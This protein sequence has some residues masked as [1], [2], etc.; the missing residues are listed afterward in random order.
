MGPMRDIA[1]LLAGAVRRNGMVFGAS[2]HRAE[3]W[4]FFEGGMQ[5]PSDVKEPL[6]SGLYG[7]AFPR[8]T[9]FG[10]ESQPT[11]TFLNDWLA[12]TVELVERYR[13]QVLWF[14]WWIEQPAFEP[15]RQKFAAYYYNQ[16]SRWNRGVVINYKL[17][18]FPEKAA[19]LDV[20]RGQLDAIR[21]TTWQTDTSVSKKS[22]GYVQ[23]DEFKT[24]G[25]IVGDL[26]DIVSKN[27]TL[28][29][30]VGPRADGTIPQEAQKILLDIGRWLEVNGE[31]VYGSRPWRVFGE[32]PTQVVA[33]SFKDT[34]RAAFT[35]QDFRFTAKGN[36]LY[37]IALAWPR[38]GRLVVRSLA[39]GSPHGG[40]A[41]R[42]VTLLGSNATLRW[43]RNADG[44]VVELPGQPPCDYAYVLKI[45][46]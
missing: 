23:N 29:L 5:V 40:Q 35:S 6:N 15:Y 16:A 43:S 1:S 30:N 14:D 18:A 36:V 37:V 27:G 42:N 2:S 28:L 11:E 46:R 8:K 33:G 31:A 9:G 39:E 20:E 21:P 44:L 10:A 26:A 13:P 45:S 25:S 17:G 7:P 19:V 4:W 34:E 22:W 38:D 3:H 12:R 41:I 24:A 32:G